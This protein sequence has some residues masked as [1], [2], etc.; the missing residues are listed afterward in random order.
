MS[1]YFATTRRIQAL[2]EALQP[3]KRHLRHTLSRCGYYF[4][5]MDKYMHYYLRTT[6]PKR[7]PPS[8]VVTHSKTDVF[9]N[10]LESDQV[11]S[12]VVC[13]H[14]YNV[15][16]FEALSW[17]RILTDTMKHLDPLGQ[18]V[19]TS[20]EDLT[21]TD[22]CNITNRTAFI[23][24]SWPSRGKVLNYLADQG[25]AR[26]SA[27][28]LG[29]LLTRLRA[30]G[31]S[32]NL[33]CHSMGNLLACHAL[34]HLL[35][36]QFHS[37]NSSETGDIK[38][39]LVRG[40]RAKRNGIETEQVER[41]RWLV[42]NYVMIAPDV[43]RRHVTRCVDDETVESS[44]HGPF[45]SGLQHLVKNKVN[46]FSRFDR[47]L[48]IS[49]YEKSSR[50]VRLGL[51]ETLDKWTLGLLDFRERNP[52]QRWE[53]RLGQGPAPVNA[54]PTIRSVNATELANRQIGHGDHIDAVPV[55]ERIAREL[56]IGIK[57]QSA[58]GAREGGGESA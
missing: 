13:V 57:P 46:F 45:Y 22:D 14:G 20:A 16:F 7:I 12:I 42:D 19:I 41:D 47:A 24:F 3:N 28:A 4:V 33:L 40:N 11:S 36:G 9:T 58:A 30:T 44:Y 32:V 37:C 51:R 23:G 48:A 6:E 1:T 5:D 56:K 31:R 25:A 18:Y 29:A 26:A 34:S 55:V 2:G 17:F 43:E 38:K 27:S 8:A 54:A 49:D 35:D 15:H 21:T 10:F 39:L 53:E 50:E 52:D